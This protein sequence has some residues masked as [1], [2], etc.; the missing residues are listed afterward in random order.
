MF[1]SGYKSSWVVDWQSSVAIYVL[2]KDL[3]NIN[4]N[5][6]LIKLIKLYRSFYDENHWII[7]GYKYFRMMYDWVEHTT[8]A[9]QI[10]P[11]EQI[12]KIMKIHC[13]KDNVQNLQFEFDINTKSNVLTK[14]ALTRTVWFLS[15]IEMVFTCLWRKTES[16]FLRK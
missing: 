7:L 6:Q 12:N 5:Y 3:N 16:F 2:W 9:V 1:K 8:R 11:F 14:P 4:S 13:K 15:T 10:K